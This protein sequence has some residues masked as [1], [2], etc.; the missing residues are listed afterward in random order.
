[1]AFPASPKTWVTAA[2]V[3]A[4]QLNAELRDAVRALKGLDG[5]V[6]LDDDLD[7]QGNY[8]KNIGTNE[9]GDILYYDGTKWVPLAHGTSGQFLKTQGNAANPIWANQASVEGDETLIGIKTFQSIPVLPASDPTTANQAVRMAALGIFA[10]SDD[11]LASVDT[12]GYTY[13]YSTP[14][15]S[16]KYK[17]AARAQGV[18]RVKF[19]IKSEGEPTIH[20]QIY[21]NGTA[22]GTDRSTTSSSYVTYSEDISGIKVGDVIQLYVWCTTGWAN[23]WHQNF[24]IYGTPSLS[25]NF[26]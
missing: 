15:S 9:Q 22:I 8:L 16:G 6:Q 19:D 26:S 2:K 20:G 14:I 4:A 5:D 23:V 13:A 24:R 11:L 7:L 21:K 25:A 3:T 17:T 1:M 12:E 10:A 18:L